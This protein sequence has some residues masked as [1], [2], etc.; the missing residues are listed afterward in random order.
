MLF[1]SHENDDK[2]FAAGAPDPGSPAARP[3]PRKV[4]FGTPRHLPRKANRPSQYSIR[5]IRA[6]RGQFRLG[7]QLLAIGYLQ[8]GSHLRP[9]TP[10]SSLGR[11]QPPHDRSRFWNTLEHL[12]LRKCLQMGVWN[13]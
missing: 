2:P 3:R 5:A 12:F 10:L 13:N 11:S 1:V 7:Y 6:I 9:F 4:P 8:F